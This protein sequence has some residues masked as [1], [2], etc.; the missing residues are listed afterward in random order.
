MSRSTSL[1]LGSVCNFVIPIGIQIHK[2]EPTTVGEM[3]REEFLK[4]LNLTQEQLAKAMGVTAKVVN[5]IVNDQR[6]I[7]LDEA[8]LLARLFET[9][10][11][12]WLNI[13][14]AHDRWVIRQKNN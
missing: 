5:Q 8:L 12:F 3:L 4:P 10:S 6:R 14:V 11:S 2:A 1:V 13:Q 9:D 7:T